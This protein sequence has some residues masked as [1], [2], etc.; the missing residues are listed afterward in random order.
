MKKI[1]LVIIMFFVL[2]GCG[3]NSITTTMGGTKE[4]D[5]PEGYKFVNYNIQDS[6][7]RFH[8]L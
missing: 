6:D 1:F 3:S 7:Y 5:I 8:I 4:I 2:C